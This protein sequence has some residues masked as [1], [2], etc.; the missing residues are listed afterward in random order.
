MGGDRTLRSS[1]L[2]RRWVLAVALLAAGTT[3]AWNQKTH[4][5]VNHQ[6]VEKFKI[7][8]GGAGKYR[9]GP[10]DFD[11]FYTGVGLIGAR[12]LAATTSPDRRTLQLTAW[13][14]EGGD[15]ADEPQ[16]YAAV[17]HFYDPLALSGVH[18]LTDQS[19]AHGRYD[20]PMVDAVT[21]ALSATDNPFCWHEALAAYKRAMETPEDG[22]TPGEIRGS[23]FK[24][25]IALHP[26]DRAEEREIHLAR[27]Y[28]ALGETMHLLAD[29]V[30][31][32]H[33][34]NDSH[35]RDEPVE[36]NVHAADVLALAGA[37][38][39][40]KM[41]PDLKSAGGSRLHRP[42]Q[43]F[44]VLASFTNRSFYSSDTVYDGPSGVNP[45][46]QEIP[47]PRPQ[48]K[49]LAQRK[50]KV[51]TDGTDLAGATEEGTELD[52][53][54]APFLG[55]TI[56]LAT[57]GLYWHYVPPSF[58][59]Q[60]ARVLIPIAIHAAADLMH[61]FFP[62]L[63]LE[64]RFDD[65][66]LLVDDPER[67]PLARHRVEVEGTMVHRVDQDPAWEDEGLTISYTGAADL[68]FERNGRLRRTVPLAFQ[69]GR[70]ARFEDHQ[71][72]MVDSPLRLYLRQGKGPALPKAEAHTAVEDGDAV[73]V[74]VKAGSRTFAGPKLH[75]A[76]PVER[77][78]A[79]FEDLGLRPD[80]GAPAMGVRRI[81]VTAE[82]ENR[83]FPARPDGTQLAP[84]YTG[85][86]ELAFVD[87]RG[88]LSKT[89]PVWFE[90]GRLTRI[91][92]PQGRLV[93]EPLV[94]YG[95]ESSRQKLTD[96]EKLYEV[97]PEHAV[98]LVLWVDDGRLIRSNTWV[99]GVESEEV[100]GT[101]S[102]TLRLGGTEKLR[103]WVVT[104]FSYGFYPV[105]QAIAKATNSPPLSMDQVRT[106]VDG[107]TTS[108]VV[109][110]PLALTV[111]SESPRR[112]TVEVTVT[113]DEGV[114]TRATSA[115]SYANGELRFK[116]SFPDGSEL[117]MTGR[118]QGVTLTGTA[119]GRAWGVVTDAVE[120]S[121]TVRRE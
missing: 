8:F 103:R 94:L 109:E 47:Y 81:A 70:L 57:K 3:E 30:Q 35:P 50:V 38:V 82:A 19:T 18:Y 21:W 65:P 41:V 54:V 56:P 72:E 80:E 118:L 89:V 49:D 58:A 120:G 100:D 78:D 17:R 116:V 51:K 44:F 74:R 5:A 93:T 25:D 85:A 110:V 48:F 114:E 6:A 28:R 14:T 73:Y 101:Y 4:K 117:D 61:Q 76:F 33:V 20:Q 16:L 2:T 45:R 52:A 27:A 22:Q 102:G 26:K 63:E 43:L 39:D 1:S 11:E 40:A 91:S 115:G 13:V 36:D 77:V 60:Q 121:W 95:D 15:W 68:V 75:Y 111:T 12:Y 83:S 10:V 97:K 119:T 106:A 86:M 98:S 108:H 71:G 7:A 29:M 42:E 88:R 99:Y 31:P 37:P 84:A 67:K 104:M 64:G 87:E 46:N 62:T 92:D 79:V 112:V 96:R 113:S 107:A 9:L 23:H 90:E 55:D 59:K 24:L 53:W 105:A 34:R 69:Q 66:E 32:A